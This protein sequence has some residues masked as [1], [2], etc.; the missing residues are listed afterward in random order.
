MPKDKK[1]LIHAYRTQGILEAARKVI[2]ERGFDNA[3]MGEVA[4]E[5]GISKATIYLYFKNKDELYFNCVLEKLDGV[6]SAIKE[7]V[8]GIDDPI[9]LLRVAIN[10]QIKKAEEDEDFFR[11]FLTEKMTVFLNTETEFGRE[12]YRRHMEYTRI[13]S[14]ALEEGMKRGLIRRLDPYKCSQTLLS[15]IRGMAILKII[16]KSDRPCSD[17][18]DL[19]F[20]LFLNGVSAVK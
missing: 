1:A 9:E 20:D 7:A 10:V 12:Y 14:G 6:I 2:A 11:V 18:V 4:A 17:E 8:K 13:L 19:I 3:T 16:N 15:M 5:A